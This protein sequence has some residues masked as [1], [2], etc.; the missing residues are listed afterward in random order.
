MLSKSAIES[1]LPLA[2]EA[3]SR[4]LVIVPV[5]GSVLTHLCEA[6]SVP[7]DWVSAEDDQNFVA[8]I[9]DLINQANYV[10][11]AN[12]CE[13]NDVL[14][15]AAEKYIGAVR[16]QIQQARVVVS[17]MA[18]EYAEGIIKHL[19]SYTASELL[20]LE[21]ITTNTPKPLLNPG[22]AD[23]LSKYAESSYEPIPAL[24]MPEIPV[25]ELEEAL[26]TGAKSLDEDVALWLADCSP[27]WLAEVW[28]GF[29]EAKAADT[30]RE[31]MTRPKVGVNY[32]LAIWLLAQH[33]FNNP[34]EGVVKDLVVYNQELATVRDQS[35]AQLWRELQKI[36]RAVETGLM[37]EGIQGT[38]IYVNGEVYNTWIEAGGSTDALFGNMYLPRPLLYAQ[39]LSMRQQELESIWAR[40]EALVK[41][42]E[43]LNKLNRVQQIARAKF[44]DLLNGLPMDVKAKMPRS[45][46][47]MELMDAELK[48]LSIKCI[49][50]IYSLAL[51]L[52][53][54]TLFVNSDA[55]A[56]LCGI[57]RVSKENPKLSAQEA[58]SI[59]VAEYIGSW[60]GQQLT[61]RP[62]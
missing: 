9:N 18:Q 16:N 44:V 7:M 19:E 42:T 26:K 6:S 21:I 15:L 46:R 2:L 33:Y 14:D 25:A 59:A 38:K 36:L 61:V 10:D 58:A 54:R 48:S 52:L 60:V 27:G 62:I 13:H 1:S 51:R 31:M 57:E 53:C 34:P 39:E 43:K 37:V 56:I 45:A 35:A 23:S 4:N 29:K 49:E 22:L 50:N 11:P 55:E 17:P 8:P 32:A 3:D 20:G 30:L 24:G 12:R 5:A 28:E 47:L 41:S 40:Q